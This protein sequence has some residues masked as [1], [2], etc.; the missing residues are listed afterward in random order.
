MKKLVYGLLVAASVNL[1][2]S[3]GSKPKP[4]P[5]PIEEPKVVEVP[6]E[7][8][9]VEETK[10]DNSDALGKTENA[11]QAAIDAGAKETSPVQFAAVDKLYEA[12]QAQAKTGADVSKG[13]EDV[14]KRYNAL[15]K[16][17][18]A[19]QAKKRIDELGLASADQAKYDAG[20]A[21]LNELESLFNETN[22][23]GEKML[24]KADTAKKS[25]D[26]VL[27][28]GFKNLAKDER[29]EA[30]KAKRDADSIK[31]GV[32]SKEAYDK[33][34]E[35][36]RAGDSSY[37]MQNPESA[38]A[39]YKTSRTQF[40]EVYT[41]VLARR[42][43][44]SKAMEEARIRVAESQNY[45]EKADVEAPLVGE[46]I[47]GIEAADAKLLDDDNYADPETQKADIPESIDNVSTGDEK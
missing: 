7:K 44:A 1:L 22:L 30:F 27:F 37:A 11:R 33:A 36:F 40:T 47:K 31:A 34:V 17:A 15:E 35:E 5:N 3:C 23:T 39:H 6:E 19:V 4:E 43:A 28:T 8:P 46:N 12:L 16:Y 41:T 9:V 29:T 32:A 2:F 26:A 21:A 45:A 24:A 10:V 14:Q 42:E 20:C 38:Y 18:Q 13:L 25:F